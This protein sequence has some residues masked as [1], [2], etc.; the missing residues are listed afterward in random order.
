MQK[1]CWLSVLILACSDPITSDMNNGQDVDDNG[2]ESSASVEDTADAEPEPEPEVLQNPTIQFASAVCLFESESIWK[3]D[4]V[5]VDPQGNNTLKSEASCGVYRA[6]D[7]MGDPVQR[8]T[9]D[10]DAGACTQAEYD[11]YPS[12]IFCAEASEW[13]FHFRIMDEEGHES[14]VMVVTGSAETN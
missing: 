9:L 4:L 11:G 3:L 8:V 7:S 10:C 2:G 12:S 6:G 1:F 5:A 14:Q 13:D